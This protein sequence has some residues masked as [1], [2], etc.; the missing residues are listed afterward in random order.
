MCQR[1]DVEMIARHRKAAHPAGK[2]CR[3]ASGA[4]AP[5]LAMNRV[6]DAVSRIVDFW[7][8]AKTGR[9]RMPQRIAALSPLPANPFGET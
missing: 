5:E 4:G 8:V 6:R 9:L 7:V 3:P 2:W 1:S